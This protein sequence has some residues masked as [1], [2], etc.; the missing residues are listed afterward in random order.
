MII[1]RLELSAAVVAVKLDRTL[2]EELEIKIDRSVL[3]S[4]STA[5]LQYIKNEDKQFHTFVANR[6]AVI[7]DGSKPSQWNFVE[8]ARNPAD[9]VS[10][11]LTPEELLLHDRW[12]KGPEFLRK[13][14][15]SWPV[16]SSP[17]PSIPDQD[18]EIKSQGQ[19]NCITMVS[20]EG[21]LNLMIQRYLSWYELKRGMAWLLRLREYI[22]RKHY[23]PDDLVPQGELSLEELRS[24]ELQFVK[25]I[26][27][28]AFPEIFGALQA[29]S[30][31]TQEKRALR[32]SGSSGSI[33]KL[34]PML[35]KKGALR[36]GGRL[37][38]A[39]L[40]YQSKH[41]LLLAHNHYVSRLLIMAHHQSV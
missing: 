16:P 5:V 33:Y 37:V 24:A 13:Q 41:Q 4:D 29:S 40:N 18:P 28:L 15:E 7:H 19:T 35:D 9:D 8:S 1:P 36:V 14:E 22:R 32:T 10:R 25:Y 27:R 30:S 21:S 23:P 2:K 3:W 6:L 38:N 34:R 11:G 39:S 26:Q 12:F 17:L 31:K 20:E